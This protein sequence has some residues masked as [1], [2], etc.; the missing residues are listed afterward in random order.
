MALSRLTYTQSEDESPAQNSKM[1]CR[2]TQELDRNA[3]K[4]FYRSSLMFRCQRSA[5]SK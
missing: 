1:Q 2:Q 4:K 3:W 5:F